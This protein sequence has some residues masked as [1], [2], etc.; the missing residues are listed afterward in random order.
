MVLSS[1]KASHTDWIAPQSY[2]ILYTRKRVTI[3]SSDTS[4][5]GL[6]MLCDG[7]DFAVFAWYHPVFLW[8]QLCASAVF[9]SGFAFGKFG[10]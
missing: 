2:S 6:A 7:A 1:R 10:N 5:I 4:C 9:G 3:V 8:M